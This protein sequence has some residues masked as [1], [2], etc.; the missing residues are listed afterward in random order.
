MS[1]PIKET[2]IGGTV[3]IA[4]GIAEGS[5]FE[6]FMSEIETFGTYSVGISDLLA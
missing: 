5:F 4:S 2:S 1:I 6:V 3:D